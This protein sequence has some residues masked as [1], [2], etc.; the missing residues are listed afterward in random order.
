[1]ER[2]EV[3][4]VTGQKQVVVLTPAEEA[5]AIARAAA[6]EAEQAPIRAQ[7]AADAAERANLKQD[8]Q[9]IN[10][11]MRP[12]SEVDADLTAGLGDL[13]TAGQRAFLVT[14]VKRLARVAQV[15]ARRELR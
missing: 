6:E 13:S 4:V 15:M 1:M 12:W 2:I 8:A 9:T 5:E 3:N 14:C 7:Q 11:L 10:F